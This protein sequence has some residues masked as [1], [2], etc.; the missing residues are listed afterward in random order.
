MVAALEGH[1]AVGAAAALVRED[2]P[3]D[4]RL[5]GYVV[6]KAGSVVEVAEVRGYLQQQVPEYLVPSA[7]VV[8]ERLP[9]TGNGKLDRGA[10]PALDTARPQLKSAYVAPRTPVEQQLATIWQDLLHIDQVGIHD[11][12]FSLG[13]DSI[14][15]IQLAARLTELGLACA[16]KD[17]FAAP[18]IA[19]LAPLLRVA[20]APAASA[21]VGPVPLTPIQHW[22]LD[23]NRPVPAHFNQSLL[24]RLATPLDLNALQQALD[25]LLEHHDA[26]RLRFSQTMQGWLQ[27]QTPAGPPAVLDQ[28]PWDASPAHLGRT[29]ASIQTA[30]DLEAGPLLRACYLHSPDGRDDRLL[31]VAHHLVIDGV[32]WRVLL[33]DLYQTYNQAQQGQAVA[34]P[35]RTS[36][37]AAWATRLTTLQLEEAERT[38]WRSVVGG[39]VPPLP[40]DVPGASNTEGQA[41]RIVRSL[42]TAQTQALLG[43]VSAHTQINDLLITALFLSV[44]DWAGQNHLLIDLESHGRE[45]LFDDIDLSRT[46]GWFTALFPVYLHADRSAP[47]E[48]VLR[49][50]RTQ[51]HR[52]P[53][54]GIGYGLL[55]YQGSDPALRA[56]LAGLPQAEISFNYLGQFDGLNID[57]TLFAVASESTEPTR[58]PDGPRSHLIEV[59]GRVLGGQ[60]QMSWTYGS[61][62]YRPETITMLAETFLT[63]LPTLVQSVQV[64][65]SNDAPDGDAFNWSP[66]DLDTIAAAIRKTLGTP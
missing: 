30:L 16:P 13:G 47:V 60:L 1:P 20:A 66:D 54:R 21:P 57:Q 12:F 24:L 2:T 28:R 52:I 33:G 55:R 41:Q 59:V 42:S 34:L 45:E 51:L 5:V 23:Q 9:L 18:T 26:L 37:F 53:R 25:A 7:L 36:S 40:R 49:S 62:I 22:F 39:P 56:E 43:V 14:H 29:I 6:A 4:R 31:L 17:L 44:A 10:L 32:S 38:Y 19:R 3:G 8:L 63:A 11:N 46:I 35:P 15:A 61:Q 50:V 27:S 64:A 48:T 65:N 58:H